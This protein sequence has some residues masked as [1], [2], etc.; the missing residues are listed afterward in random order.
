MVLEKLTLLLMDQVGCAAEDVTMNA[1]LDDLNL[2]PDDRAELAF[3][4]GPPAGPKQENALC[5]R[6]R[7]S[8]WKR[9][10]TISVNPPCWKT[11]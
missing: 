7:C 4:L 11:R 10:D 8:L 5:V 1:R 6:K 2:T 9:S 3:T